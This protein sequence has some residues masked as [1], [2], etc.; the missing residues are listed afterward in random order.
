VD[1][2]IYTDKRWIIDIYTSSR[3]IIDI[4]TDK[5]WIIDLYTGSLID[6]YRTALLVLRGLLFSRCQ[7]N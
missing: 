3:E 1:I 4:Y 2:D 5:R 7:N 6:I